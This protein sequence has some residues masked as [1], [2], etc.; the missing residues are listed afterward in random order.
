M[1]TLISSNS[2]NFDDEYNKFKLVWILSKYENKLKVLRSISVSL[3]LS[4]SLSIYL[5][6]SLSFSVKFSKK[7][8]LF[9]KNLLKF[10]YR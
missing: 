5:S 2:N 7:Y 10:F 9:E 4:L 8:T 6:L 1:S 3:S